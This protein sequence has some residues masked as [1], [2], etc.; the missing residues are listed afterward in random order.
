MSSVAIEQ[1]QMVL[2]TGDEIVDI[3]QGHEQETIKLVQAAYQTHSLGDSELPHSTFLRFPKQERD[4]IIALTAYL[5]GD[6]NVAGL[7]WIASFPNNIQQGLE[8][9]SATL[10]LNAMENGRPKA[11]MESSVISAQRTAAGAAL[12]ADRL[13]ENMP[14]HTVGMI[15]CGLINYETFRF[16]LSVR[17]EV[18]TVYVYDVDSARAEQFKR[19]CQ[20]YAGNIEIVLKPDM[21]SILAEAEVISLATT[22]VQPHIHDLSMCSPDSVIL[23]TSLRDISAEAILSVDN[24]VDDVDHC[25]RAQTSVHLAEQHS[26]D[27][28]FIRCTIGDILL[29]NVR[30]REQGKPVVYSAF[31]LGIL[32]IALG[33][34]VYKRALE[35]Q[36]GTRV[37]SFFPTNWLER[38]GKL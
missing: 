15:G 20:E 25:C 11:I 28:A 3:L 7:K 30:S 22:A 4:R 17:P 14:L 12:A 32:D 31:G 35:Q 13:W 5:G 34:Y 9:A 1:G 6:F 38:G 8:R 29:G 23:H 18:H 24:I 27:R 37:G 33:E 19:K 16:L 10:I 26:G 36:A 21:T 2:L